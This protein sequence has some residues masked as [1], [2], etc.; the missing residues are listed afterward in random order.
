MFPQV[1][2]DLTKDD[3]TL[4]AIETAWNVFEG[5]VDIV[6]NNSGI[7][8]F[9]PC[10]DLTTEAFDEVMN[11][12]LRG[13]FVVSRKFAKRMVAAGKPGSIVNVS[14]GAGD[15]AL[16]WGVPY[17]ASKV[18]HLDFKSWSRASDKFSKILENTLPD[19]EGKPC[20][21]TSGRFLWS[22]VAVR[23]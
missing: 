11:V 10:L 7:G 3:S 19:Y 23:S 20:D 14:S 18:L 4:S 6:V 22:V 21:R 1:P 13:A 17:C 8:N 12:N 16:M 9:G 2:L 15:A 5:G